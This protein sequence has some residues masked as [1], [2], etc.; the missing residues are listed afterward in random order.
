MERCR[1]ARIDELRRVWGRAA[2]AQGVDARDVDV[3]LG[4]FLERPLSWILAHGEE[5]A[6]DEVIAALR[7]AMQRRLAREPLQ[8]VRGRTEFYGRQFLVD[9][10]VLIPRPETEHLV[11]EAARLLPSGSRILEIGT[12]SG[13]VAT[14]LSL[15]RADLHIAATDVSLA[16]L[17]LASRNCRILGARVHFAASDV[18][19]SVWGRFAAIVSNPPYVPAGDVPRLQ[20]EVRDHEPEIAL[21]PGATGLEVTE[22]ILEAAPR[23][24]ESG[25]SILLEI[26][27]TQS[28][29][30]RALAA[31]HGWRAKFRDDLAGIPRVAIL[32][33][34]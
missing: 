16:A 30:V 2:Q 14:T 10:R 24:V 31:R 17:A 13:C 7:G 11:E 32:S 34:S 9:E 19:E 25:G 23:L 6:P 5:A 12:G 33:S 28:E 18:C 4:D 21:T 20:P 22:R 15:E 26:G 3:L 27:F 1:L 29:P 8:Y